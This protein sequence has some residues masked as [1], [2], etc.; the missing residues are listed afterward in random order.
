VESKSQAN[1]IASSVRKSIS[2]CEKKELE[3]AGEF[4]A[5]N[6]AAEKS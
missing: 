3:N 5:H 2:G 4:S 1:S 6:D